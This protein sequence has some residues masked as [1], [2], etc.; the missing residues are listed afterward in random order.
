MVTADA[1]RLEYVGLLGEILARLGS[2]TSA[3]SIQQQLADDRRLY[4]YG[5]PQF[6]SARIAAILGDRDRA[7]QLL[8]LAKQRGYPYD[9]EFHRDPA[10]APLRG[11]AVLRQLEAQRE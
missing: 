7:V 1:T 9:L 3:R 10:L 8:E 4:T 2:T 5:R 6:L 11:L